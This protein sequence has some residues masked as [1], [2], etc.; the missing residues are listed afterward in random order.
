[1]RIFKEPNLSRSWKCPICRTRKSEEVV[2]IRIEETHSGQI[3]KAEQFHVKCLELTW[4][5]ECGL[6]YQKI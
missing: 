4:D 2:L 5:K 1:M 3:T 6:I